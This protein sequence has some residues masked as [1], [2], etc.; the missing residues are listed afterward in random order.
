VNLGK[1]IE[2]LET[3]LSGREP[4]EIYI[5]RFTAPEHYERLS[6]CAWFAVLPGGEIGQIIP[7]EGKDEQLD[8][9]D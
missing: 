1:R 3:G 5:R 8:A 7:L 6:D 2:R 9:T 4:P